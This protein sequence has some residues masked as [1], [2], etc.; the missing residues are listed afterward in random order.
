MPKE[1]DLDRKERLIEKEIEVIGSDLTELR[2]THRAEHDTL[3][4]EVAVLKMFLRENFPDFERQFAALKEK[5]GR[6]L[7]GK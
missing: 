3:Q 6:E 4:L 1:I 2:R 7:P 5:A